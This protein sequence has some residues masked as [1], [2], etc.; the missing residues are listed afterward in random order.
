MSLILTVDCLI[1]QVATTAANP[2]D[3]SLNPPLT[4]SIRVLTFPVAI[5]VTETLLTSGCIHFL[6]CRFRLQGRSRKSSQNETCPRDFQ[7]TSRG[8]IPNVHHT[9]RVTLHSGPCLSSTWCCCCRKLPFA[10][11]WVPDAPEL[12]PL[13]G[14][15][16]CFIICVYVF[17]YTFNTR[18]WVL[19]PTCT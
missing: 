7:T 9:C 2:A 18:T 6:L 10:S 17:G 19:W 1:M 12:H 15:Y 4:A 16:S 14:S 13:W 5:A 3:P 8:C 11:N